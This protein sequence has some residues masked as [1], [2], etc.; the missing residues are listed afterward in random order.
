MTLQNILFDLDG[1]LVDPKEGITKSIQ[2][3]LKKLDRPVP[4]IDEL[5][6]CIGPPLLENFKILFEDDDDVLAQK[7]V[8][9]YRERFADI[10]IF[11]NEVYEGIPAVLGTLQKHNYRLFVATTKPSIFAKEIVKHFELAHYFNGVY[12][13]RLNGELADKTDLLPYLLEQENLLKEQTIM[14][15]DRK[16]D[17][18]G[19]KSCGLK[20]L[21]LTYGYGGRKEL[22]EAGAD[23]LAE[24]PSEILDILT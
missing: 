24:R 16:H 11:E 10:G 3:A 9:L 8:D 4:D 13:S 21:G 7:A 6:W 15:G 14:I 23:F 17:I 20:S 12:G 1:S 22:L 18:L 5:T 2:Y 19:A